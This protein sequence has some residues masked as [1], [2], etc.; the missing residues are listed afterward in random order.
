MQGEP[1]IRVSHLREL[2]M[3]PDFEA[4]RAE[5]N[6]KVKE[7][8]NRLAAEFGGEAEL[9]FSLFDPNGCY[10]ACSTGGQCEHQW[11]GQGAKFYPSKGW[12]VTCSRC[13]ML[14][15]NHSLKNCP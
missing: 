10:C 12:S 11:N 7:T 1:F 13:G 14:A 4:L 5:R 8:I 2:L 15:L 6:A 3:K 9:I